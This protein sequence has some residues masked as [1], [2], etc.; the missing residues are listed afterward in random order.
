MSDRPNTV[1]FRPHQGRP[2]LDNT[3]PVEEEQDKSVIT[4]FYQ[5]FH[6]AGKSQ[7]KSR[8]GK[9]QE[10]WKSTMNGNPLYITPP[11]FVKLDHLQ[12]ACSSVLYL[13]MLVQIA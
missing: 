11:H 6:W 12:H 5:G 9:S 7:G 10:I 2:D 8:S 4:L 13:L 3:Q 1:S